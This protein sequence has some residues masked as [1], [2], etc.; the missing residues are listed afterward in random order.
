MLSIVDSYQLRRG[1]GQSPCP[2]FSHKAK[3]HKSERRKN[4][5]G[6]TLI[7]VLLV[8]A[9]MGVAFFPILQMFSQGYLI[10]SESEVSL[11]AISLSEKV[12]EEEKNLAFASIV[13]IAKTPVSG[14][15][16]FSKEV[17]VTDPETDLK[18]IEVIL[19]YT[20]GNSELSMR[21]KTL[22]ANF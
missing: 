6:L 21:L 15:P 9:F 10:S 5:K 18:D 22:V 4:K 13:S 17:V 20:V 11:K 19:Y 1:T 8:M 7:E 16:D 14:N 3:M 12:M 2:S